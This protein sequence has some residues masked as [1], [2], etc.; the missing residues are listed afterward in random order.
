MLGIFSLYALI[1]AGI[2]AALFVLWASQ[3]AIP[4]FPHLRVWTLRRIVYPLLIRRRRWT[5]VTYMEFALLGVY[6]AVNGAIMGGAFKSV[7][8]DENSDLMRRSGLISS[9]NTVVLFLGGRTNVFIDAFGVPLHTYY[10]AHHWIGRMAIAQ[11]LLHTIL[12]ISRKKWV[13]DTKSNS[14]L[15]VGLSSLT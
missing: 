2:F 4:Y 3:F 9:V 5:S 6:A 7:G 12:A 13:F 15:M 11:A 14:G 1:L 10:L 8:L